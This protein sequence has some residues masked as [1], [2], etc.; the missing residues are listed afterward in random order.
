MWFAIL[1]F[2]GKSKSQNLWSN[3]NLSGKFSRASSVTDQSTESNVGMPKC[4]LLQ[5]RRYGDPNAGDAWRGLVRRSPPYTFEPFGGPQT[6]AWP[7]TCPP[8]Y[9]H[10]HHCRI[11]IRGPEEERSMGRE[12]QWKSMSSPRVSTLF[13]RCPEDATT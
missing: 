11:P 10:Y 12:Q 7:T 1:E 2:S 6:R 4:K 13:E 5:S 3:G 8:F 9:S